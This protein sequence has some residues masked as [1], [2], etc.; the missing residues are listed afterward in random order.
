MF[1]NAP[2]CERV[3]FDKNF[4]FKEI[5]IKGY[6]NKV[7]CL[8]IFFFIMSINSFGSNLIFFALDFINNLRISEVITILSPSFIHSF[9]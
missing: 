8:P 7:P 9:K 5:P 4:S 3:L 1:P 2:D 6:I